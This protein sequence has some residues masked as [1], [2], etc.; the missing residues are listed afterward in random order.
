[1]VINTTQKPFPNDFFPILTKGLWKTPCKFCMLKLLPEPCFDGA[2]C[3]CPAL[4]CLLPCFPLTPL[5]VALLQGHCGPVFHVDSHVAFTPPVDRSGLAIL[6]GSTSNSLP[7]TN[8][9]GIELSSSTFRMFHLKTIR[10]VG[11]R[12]EVNDNSRR[13]Q[14]SPG[15]HL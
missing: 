14:V 3:G 7:R 8:R 4:V 9:H 10:P 5:P 2:T 13:T 1:M 15:V 12:P 11:E 6:Y